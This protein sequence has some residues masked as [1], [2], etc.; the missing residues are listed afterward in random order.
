MPHHRIAYMHK[1]IKY[2]FSP[3]IV[4]RR[5]FCATFRF[6]PWFAICWRWEER[7]NSQ[8]TGERENLARE[9]SSPPQNYF[10]LWW[11]QFRPDVNLQQ[12]LFPPQDFLTRRIAS[13]KCKGSFTRFN[14]VIIHFIKAFIR[15]CFKRVLQKCNLDSQAFCYG[16]ESSLDALSLFSFK[17]SALFSFFKSRVF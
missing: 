6:L 17:R 4:R 13:M 9:F 16:N 2:D 12:A 15:C 5:Y 14:F 7:E 3:E 8:K 10:L 1:D 11:S